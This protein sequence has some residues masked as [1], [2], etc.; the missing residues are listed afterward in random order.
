MNWLEEVQICR[1]RVKPS[2]EASDVVKAICNHS[3]TLSKLRLKNWDSVSAGKIM[4]GMNT[5]RI[6][7]VKNFE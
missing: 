2:L 7:V 3:R 5:G 4:E 6:K 1:L